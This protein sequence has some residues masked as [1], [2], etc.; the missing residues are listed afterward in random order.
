M[1]TALFIDI[2]DKR[3]LLVA[4]HQWIVVGR[5]ITDL[6]LKPYERVLFVASPAP[7][8]KGRIDHSPGQHVGKQLD[9]RLKNY[10]SM[11][12]VYGDEGPQGRLFEPQAEV[13]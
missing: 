11:R 8:L 1:K 7:Y 2:R 9:Y 13:S 6:D 3:G 5:Q 12:R 10:S 4:D